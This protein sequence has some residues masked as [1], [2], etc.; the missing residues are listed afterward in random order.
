MFP[1][2]LIYLTV[3]CL[4]F[5]CSKAQDSFEK[6][7]L[8]KEQAMQL[9]L[10]KKLREISG[11][12]FNSKG[13]LFAHDDE[14]AVIY[15]LNPETGDIV[16]SFYLGLFIK[17]ADF[18]D[19]TIVGDTFYLITANGILYKFKE[20][21]DE[22]RVDY[23]LFSTGLKKRNDV[24]GLCYD[25]KT[26]ALLL[27]LKGE[28]FGDLDKKEFR[29][30]H[31]YSLKTNTLD[32]KPRFILKKSTLMDYSKEKDFAPSGI[33]YNNS[34]GNFYLLAAVGNLLVEIKPDGQI[35]AVEKLTKKLHAQPE[36]ID[37]SPDGRLFISDEG[38]KHGTLTWY[39]KNTK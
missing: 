12:A 16:K 5:S 36:G 6:L 3:T 9:K 11:I 15:Q 13:Q 25:P 14:R 26:D 19:I 33:T 34:N 1:K 32:D 7:N 27:A 38:S 20:G 31:S 8:E 39:E 21:K 35:K 2:F 37:F 23:E 30:V 10:S 28:P 4:L 29:T 24:E 18:E 22:Q 17:R